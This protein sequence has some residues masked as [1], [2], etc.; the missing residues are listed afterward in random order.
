MHSR[1]TLSYWVTSRVAF[2]GHIQICV[3]TDYHRNMPELWVHLYYIII[4]PLIKAT[5]KS[6][7][8][9]YNMKWFVSLAYLT[10]KLTHVPMHAHAHEQTLTVHQNWHFQARNCMKSRACFLWSKMWSVWSFV[11]VCFSVA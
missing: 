6:S 5:E 2:R 8:T 4:W 1:L 3:K 10:I 9:G 11:C 7:F